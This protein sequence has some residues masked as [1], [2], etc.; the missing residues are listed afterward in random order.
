MRNRLSHLF[1]FVVAVATAVAPQWADQHQA[2]AAKIAWTA[3]TALLLGI[4][5][6][7]LASKRNA[8][9]T[10]LALSAAVVGVVAGKL[11]ENSAASLIAGNLIAVLT[12]IKLILSA[13]LPA[14]PT[15]PTTKPAP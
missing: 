7:K 10:G 14:E 8:I 6:A 9:L 3:V 4:G 13:Q 11:T 2:L 15:Q 1:L 5:T 12:Q